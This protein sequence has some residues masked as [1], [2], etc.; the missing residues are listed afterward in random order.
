ML[1]NGQQGCNGTCLCL[2]VGMGL[3]TVRLRH[4]LWQPK[5]LGQQN[6]CNVV[7]QACWLN[8]LIVC[9]STEDSCLLNLMLPLHYPDSHD[10]FCCI[11]TNGA[12]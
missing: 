6:I 1:C 2:S 5:R 12:L 4:G 9:I 3:L 11:L 7:A 8:H 10:I